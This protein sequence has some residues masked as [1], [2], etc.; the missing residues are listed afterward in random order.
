MRVYKGSTQSTWSPVCS[1]TPARYGSIHTLSSMVAFDTGGTSRTCKAAMHHVR[2]A[3]SSAELRRA[4]GCALKMACANPRAAVAVSC[5]SD[6]W[7]FCAQP[8]STFGQRVLEDS[9]VHVQSPEPRS[10]FL[11]ARTPGC[12]ALPYLKFWSM[13]H[14]KTYSIGEGVAD[15]DR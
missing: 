8:S 4:C 14:T 13:G 11:A 2:T 1:E 10:R 7:L 15:A 9:L 5:C 12:S 3:G 6:T